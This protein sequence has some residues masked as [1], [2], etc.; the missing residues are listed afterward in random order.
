MGVE[1]TRPIA[2]TASDILSHYAIAVEDPGTM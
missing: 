1:A 2:E